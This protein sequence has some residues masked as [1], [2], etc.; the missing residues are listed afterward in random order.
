MYTVYINTSRK[1]K[2]VDSY[3]RCFPVYTYHIISY[4]NIG[5]IRIKY[6]HRLVLGEM[7][8]WLIAPVLKTGI[9]LSELSR[10]RIP[11]SPFF[12]Y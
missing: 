1:K 7:A 12:F 6:K 5:F 3:Q 9:V 8:E 2:N 10:V 4:G 11:L